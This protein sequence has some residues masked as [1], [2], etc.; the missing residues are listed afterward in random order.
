MITVTVTDITADELVKIANALSG[1]NIDLEQPLQQAIFPTVDDISAKDDAMLDGLADL[2]AAGL[3][4]DSELHAS[5]KTKTSNGLWKKRKTFSNTQEAI[6]VPPPPILGPATVPKPPAPTLA[7][8]Q[9][10]YPDVVSRIMTGIT[11]K[12]FDIGAVNQHLQSYNIANVSVLEHRPDVFA[13]LLIKLG[14]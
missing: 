7:V 9:L 11:D 8:Q 6:D 12:K 10:N 2:D 1:K 3:P 4:W 14:V 5:T 13:D